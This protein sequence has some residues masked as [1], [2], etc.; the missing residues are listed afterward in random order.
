MLMK[1]KIFFFS[2]H[3]VRVFLLAR[4]TNGA[5]QIIPKRDMRYAFSFSLPASLSLSWVRRHEAQ[6]GKFTFHFVYRRQMNN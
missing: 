2:A 4:R 6:E 5:P 1:I 3:S